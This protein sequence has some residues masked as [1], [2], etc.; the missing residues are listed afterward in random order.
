MGRAELINH[1]KRHPLARAVRADKMALAALAATLGHYL[2]GQPE[3]IPVWRM[4]IRPLAE[5]AAEAEAWAGRLGAAGL[6]TAVIPGDSRVGGG[7]LPGSSLPT[8]LVAVSAPDVTVDQLAARLR[9]A[10]TPVI[11]RIQDSRLLLDPRTVLPGQAE[12]LLRAV[13]R[14]MKK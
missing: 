14:V 5:I 6:T 4:I 11:A 10:A 3:Q 8:R 12:T 13:V 1:L 7:S 2:T 9:A